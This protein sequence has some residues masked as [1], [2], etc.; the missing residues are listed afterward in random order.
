[1]KRWVH[2]DRFRV[3][4]RPRAALLLA[5]VASAAL[6]LV[7]AIRAVL[8]SDALRPSFMMV[9]IVDSERWQA[10]PTCSVAC[11]PG[12]LIRQ[13]ATG[14]PTVIPTEAQSHLAERAPAAPPS[15][16]RV[17]VHVATCQDDLSWLSCR[18]HPNLRIRVVHK[19]T[20]EH[21]GFHRVNNNRGGHQ[22]LVRMPWKDL[23]RPDQPCIE[24]VDSSH[25]TA[26]RETEAFISEI[27]ST[28]EEI[29]DDDIHV[30]VQG[31]ID[32]IRNFA[33]RT[34]ADD[35]AQIALASDLNRTDYDG[36]MGPQI[37]ALARSPHIAFASLSSFVNSARDEHASKCDNL[38]VKEGRRH[39]QLGYLHC[40]DG[41]WCAPI[42]RL[43]MNYSHTS[44]SGITLHAPRRYAAPMRASFAVSGR[45]I[46][47][48]P[49]DVWSAYHRAL[50]SEFTADA[51][52]MEGSRGEGITRGGEYVWPLLFRCCWRQMR[53]VRWSELG[54]GFECYD[55]D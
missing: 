49:R 24:H 14:C 30:F 4:D 47:E 17:V 22:K 5:G 7:Y 13:F 25:P 43:P 32:E 29:K 54:A 2:P 33:K 16:R 38:L 36:A 20:R 28:Y 35:P 6:L 39:G 34:Y 26:G 51:G 42:L 3:T 23:P 46:K 50:V 55:D 53:K 44:T 18:W 19:C 40:G 45:R 15:V 8:R 27:S 52:H 11:M 10:R 41:A 31:G 9:Q 1:M 21:P 37:S 48:T 12:P